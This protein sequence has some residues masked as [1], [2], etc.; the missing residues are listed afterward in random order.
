MIKIMQM[1]YS[2]EHLEHWVG[3]YLLLNTDFSMTS[4]SNNKT[5]E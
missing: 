2:T 5:K 3:E 1:K 4:I